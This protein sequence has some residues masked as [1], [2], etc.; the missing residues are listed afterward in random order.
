[1]K[2]IRTA[3]WESELRVVVEEDRAGQRIDA[4]LASQNPRL[5]RSQVQKIIEDG[6][7]KV[8][9]KRVKKNYKLKPRDLVVFSIPEPQKITLEPQNIP[10]N[11]IYEDGDIIVVDKPRGMVVHPAPGNYSGTLVNALLY[12]CKDLSGINGVLR[13]GIVHR[14]DKDTS[15]VIIAAK[16][17][18]AHRR[19]A[20]QIKKHEF[21]RIYTALVHGTVM[22]NR[23]IIEA[24]IGRD[25]K[26]R[27]KMAVVFK[28]S[29]PAVTYLRVLERFEDYTLLELELKTGRTHQIR[30]HMSYLKHPVVGDT[31]YGRRKNEFGIEGQLLHAKTLGI[32]HPRTGEYMEFNAELP[33]YFEEILKQIRIK[34]GK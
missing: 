24:P 8:N 9:G 21:K 6:R 18:F 19:L 30:V 28:N 34:E 32:T 13:P 17:D 1:M 2:E 31:K 3:V 16:N 11:I 12:H 33:E 27:K 23:G 22:Q 20:E 10:L 4:F 26:D 7:V 15:G 14:L 29:K 25:P 5:S